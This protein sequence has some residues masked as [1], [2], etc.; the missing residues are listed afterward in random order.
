MSPTDIT[1][2]SDFLPIVK[3]VRQA[4]LLLQLFPSLRGPPNFYP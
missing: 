1:I 3:E 4:T 2:D